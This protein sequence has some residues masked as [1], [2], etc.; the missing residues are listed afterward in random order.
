[1][2]F[3]EYKRGY[4]KEC[5][6]S[7]H[8]AHLGKPISIKNIDSYSNN[9][10][11]ISHICSVDNLDNKSDDIF[12]FTHNDKIMLQVQINR[13]NLLLE[14]D[15]GA[16]R[17]VLSS[18]I[19]SML[20]PNYSNKL[21]KYRHSISLKGVSGKYLEIKGL[22]KINMKIPGLGKIDHKFFVIENPNVTLIGRDFLYTTG[23][24]IINENGAYHL[25]FSRT[26]LSIKEGTIRN[27]SEISILPN[28]SK[29]VKIIVNN[30]LDADYCVTLL[31]RP[32][33]IIMPEVISN[34]RT[35]K[36]EKSIN[37]VLINSTPKEINVLQNK[38]KF[39]LKICHDEIIDPKEINPDIMVNRLKLNY[40]PGQVPPHYDIYFTNKRHHDYSH[41]FKLANVC[42]E[43]ITRNDIKNIE[44]Y[45]LSHTT[46]KI[47]SL[48]NS[49]F[50]S[51]EL[52]KDCV[53]NH[54]LAPPPL[55]IDKEEV[56]LKI[57]EICSK[58]DNKVKFYLKP[59]LERNME[60]LSQNSWN[61]ST[62]K[63]T[64]HFDLKKEIPKNTRIY[65]IKS[66]YTAN[67]F[68]T[69]Q[70]LLYY[71][72]IA[73]SDPGNNWGS[74]VFCIGRKT[75]DPLKAK[76]VRLLVDLRIPN[77]CLKS[78][79]SASMISCM[80]ILKE[81]PQNTKYITILDLRNAFYS[82]PYSKEVLDSGY[83]RF[84]CE[85][86]SFY[87]LKAAQ[88]SS[89][90][91][92]FMTG[93]L[94]KR[95]YLDSEDYPSFL[96]N[97]KAFF[98]DIIISCKV[99]TSLKDH[100]LKVVNI[101]DRITAAGFSLS[102]EKSTFAVDLEKDQVD[103]LGYSIS[104]NKISAS[105]KRRDEI[106]KL[107]VK[108]KTIR[109]IQKLTGIL[110]YIRP[111]LNSKELELLA[112]LPE[113]IKR[114]NLAKAKSVIWD[115]RGDDILRE[116]NKSLDENP[117]TLMIPPRNSLIVMYTDASNYTLGCVLFYV[118]LNEICTNNEYES[119]K[120]E[121]GTTFHDHIE[122]MKIP[123]CAISNVFY[124]FLELVY[125]IYY[126]YNPSVNP[127]NNHV[128]NLITRELVI[129][130]PLLIYKFGE[131]CF[132]N[133][134]KDIQNGISTSEYA[135][136]LILFSLSKILGRAIMVM[137]NKYLKVPF[138]QIGEHQE[139]SPIIIG[140]AS[141]EFQIFALKE[142]F[143]DLRPFSRINIDSVSPQF[144]FNAFKK[145]YKESKF[146]FGG[147]YSKKISDSFSRSPIHTKELAALS[148][149]LAF[150]SE[151]I[152][153]NC[154]VAIIDNSTIMHNLK[155]FK[156][157]ETQKMFRLGLSLTSEYP[158][159]QL[160]LC[161]TTQMKADLL[162]RLHN[163]D[164]FIP[165][166]IDNNLVGIN[167]YVTLCENQLKIN[168]EDQSS[169]GHILSLENVEESINLAS[170]LSMEYGI[171]HL[172]SIEKL[173]SENIQYHF[174]KLSDENYKN[175]QGVLYKDG[176]I[177]IPPTLYLAYVI[178]Y[179]IR[180]HLGINRL[181]DEM[182]N[183][184]FIENKT[185]LKNEIKNL[186]GAC[187]ICA[188]SKATYDKKYIW[189]SRYG[190]EINYSW[191]SDVIEFQKI[192][193]KKT[194]RIDG[195]LL[196]IDNVSKFVS[197]CYLESLTTTCIINALLSLFG[198]LKIPKILL[199]DNASYW[200][201]KSFQV[202]L[203]T[204]GIKQVKSA[205]IHSK[206]RSIVERSIGEFRAFSRT[207]MMQHPD[208]RP[209][210]GYLFCARIHNN[211]KLTRLPVNPHFLTHFHDTT[212]VMSNDFSKSI[213]EEF[214]DRLV[215]G[216]DE[217][218][219]KKRLDAV[220]LYQDAMIKRE[221]LHKQRM[222]ILNKNKK[223]PN[224]SEGDIV[225]I[226]KFNRHQKHLPIFLYDPNVIIE[227]RSKLVICE[228]LL[229]G[230]IRNRAVSHVKKI[231]KIENFNFPKELLLKHKIYSNELLQML[232]DNIE[233]EAV[234]KDNGKNKAVTRSDVKNS[235]NESS[236]EE[237]S[238]KEV[239]FHLV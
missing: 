229:T 28:S 12:L 35:I 204:F 83:S 193:Y 30:F 105:G 174:D 4:I 212:Y 184:Y 40:H 202:F 146:H 155:N 66:E 93:Y 60:L 199:T 50:D 8:G 225:V 118:P 238:P 76:A 43:C 119:L 230:V 206:S 194:Y 141:N 181:Y 108:P 148:Q 157:R 45:H 49:E 74:P 29:E 152:K 52:E 11:N 169:L 18:N 72:I 134:V 130:T 151:Y 213:L 26:N 236:D 32:N 94:I 61:V 129:N 20:I 36:N 16:S 175:I 144:I 77:S 87:F 138:I 160:C 126:C 200:M 9:V 179:H 162:T 65:P 195:L 209:E 88:G 149:S 219:N 171:G 100:F 46:E 84:V 203:N 81:I 54:E 10:N 180:K 79:V 147:V 182:I 5:K 234:E 205:P 197:I 223:P 15:T 14:V 41:K 131:E 191:S 156:G 189:N 224:L 71:K 226:K 86:G 109:D 192:K 7:K 172:V 102:L 207:F 104:Q 101:L 127:S 114:T 231:S 161:S 110:N 33:G 163:S 124:E 188:C 154:C 64:L 176:K 227:V 21:K 125:E 165:G 63:E 142:I 222:K 198:Q 218:E 37:I 78:D 34:V 58:Y 111:V 56:R 217:N 208:I 196:V 186:L 1:M 128:I 97:V 42:V 121:I 117:L 159:L 123:V 120:C 75:N 166:P 112:E 137:L 235:E 85:F 70:Y 233:M 92:S 69:L 44:E 38:A 47:N 168:Y 96:A 98:D 221:E 185:L 237:F 173:V 68:A 140:M 139:L 113:Y 89:I 143:L 57:E 67:F 132:K 145:A 106:K 211:T 82:I 90:L 24:S 103:V 22:Y 201:S 59:A 48:E 177:V 228:S 3:T 136:H 214:E 6:Y 164:E 239:D 31:D 220:K 187:L 167:D 2:G 170:T 210:L 190:N 95:L 23:L 99:G 215:L 55:D 158:R 183:D 53:M 232:K 216:N 135:C 62:T 19:L 27:K 178:K 51:F 115:E 107:L 13:K 73:R 153:T 116:M 39:L 80:D 91:P 133:I 17:S 25:R 150:F 122:C